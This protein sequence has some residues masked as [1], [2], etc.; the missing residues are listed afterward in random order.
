MSTEASGSEQP[1][2]L[3]VDDEPGLADLYA[4]WL[5]ETCDTRVAYSG[6][7]A[8][9]E[10]DDSVDIVLLDRRMPTLSGDEVAAE[11]RA[12][13]LDCLVC[14]V[15]AVDADFDLVEIGID[16]YLQKPVS[17][18]QLQ[19]VADR[20]FARTRLPER[21]RPLLADLSKLVV[22]E[23]TRPCYTDGND[24]YTRLQ[25]RVDRQ[26]AAIAPDD[27]SIDWETL[28]TAIREPDEA[29]AVAGTVARLRD[30]FDRRERVGG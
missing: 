20:L 30:Q 28:A 16:E 11:I 18:A 25:R 21:Y 3:V 29:S 9:C 15:T 7:A 10:L 27:T 2:V 26:L 5:K 6:R 22:I 17:Q 23:G 1:V 8:L 13:G 14:M 24:A 4:V 19:E 12:K